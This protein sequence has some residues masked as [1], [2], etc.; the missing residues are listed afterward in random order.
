MFRNRGTVMF[1]LIALAVAGSVHAVNLD[2][3]ARQLMPAASGYE[4]PETFDPAA[5]A[6]EMELLHQRLWE[7]RAEAVPIDLGPLTDAE[8]ARLEDPFASSEMKMLVGVDRGLDAAVDPVLWSRPGL[9]AAQSRVGGAHTLY[10]GTFVWTA[11]LRSPGA[12]A[13]RAH[14]S[15]IDLPAGAKLYAYSPAGEAYGPYANG[16]RG[17]HQIWTNT[18]AGDTL[19]LQLELEGPVTREQLHGAWFVID[20]V[21][22]MGPQF[23]LARWAGGPGAKAF[24]DGA[25]G[26]V[27]AS[28]VENADCSNIPQ[29]I[30]AAK[31]AV[32]AMLF[33]SRGSFY[34]CSGGLLADVAGSG[35]PYFLTANHCLS[36]GNEASSLE[37]YFDHTAP[38]G[39][40]SC[41]YGWTSGRVAPG[42][43][44]LSSNRTAD[45]TLVQ[46]DAI[47]DGRRFLG[48]NA[49][50]VAFSNG[51]GLYRISH[52]GGAPQAYSEHS[53]DTSAGTCTSWPRGSWIYSRDTFGATEGG[54]SG[55]PVLNAAGEVVGQLSG[56]CG[57][58][59]N[60]S[61]DSTS[62]ATVDG[63]F[64]DYYSAVSQWLDGDGGG[65]C[66]P[67]T[68][69]CDGVDNDCD[70]L[71]D[72]DGVCDGG[73]TC[74]LGQ[75]GDACTTD[76]DCCSS[77]CRGKPGSMTCR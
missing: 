72:E 7:S 58:N 42:S 14:L 67:E 1:A 25:T 50:P 46:L 59:V 63:A 48:W 3:P 56:A 4:S 77:K 62:N 32:A 27:N 2:T 12:T 69:V 9:K 5:A 60:D 11:V 73:G 53:V 39:T 29:A 35:T 21:G 66:T 54:S 28:C 61:C 71:V 74:D 41:D 37:T 18:V 31:S 76:A 10:D 20:S 8:R 38:C 36:K 65:G 64:A 70:G 57:F 40:T 17:D 51:A 43:T 68:E 47:P 34:I 13:V 6:L 15:D 45:Y 26:P 24:C 23:E 33:Q 44:L 49:S 75:V 30:T 16:P 52:P 22:H 55:S 19:L